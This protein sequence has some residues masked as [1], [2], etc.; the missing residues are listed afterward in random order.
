MDVQEGAQQ[1]WKWQ[2]QHF[3]LQTSVQYLERGS[4]CISK[5][6]PQCLAFPRN[7]SFLTSDEIMLPTVFQH[8]PAAHINGL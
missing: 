3:S 5:S 2:R 6:T 1:W 4:Q 8:L 7:R